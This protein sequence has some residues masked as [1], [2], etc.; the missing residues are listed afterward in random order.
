[1][2]NI[3]FL[4]IIV[5]FVSCKKNS[6]TKETINYSEENL[7][8]TTSIYPKNISKVFKAH[9][10]LDTWNKMQGLVF[11][12][13]HP[14]GNEKTTTALKSRESLI[15]TETFKIGF[16]GDNVWL[17]QEDS[18]AYK[19]NA[20]FYYNLMFYFYAMPFILADDGIIYD[21]VEALVF[22]G[23]SYPGIKVSYESGIGESSEDEYVL[24]YDPETNKMTWL[25]YTVTY[26]SKEKSK[27]FRY[28]NYSD[29]QT[30]DGLL[31]PKTLTWYN[32]ENNVPTTKK[33]DM[34]F[35]NIKLSTDKPNKDLFKVP[36]GATL[37]E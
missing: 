34:K 3:L 29:W 22:E 4:A 16:D 7:D 21:E 17:K 5:L 8:V 37:V 20:R 31:L 27:D 28:I 15:E 32:Y 2:K 18:L 1:M 25:S 24:Y 19:G 13:E 23:K 10:G 11:E 6:G 14:E 36:E 26:F 35:T 33:N 9:G 30:I 12:I